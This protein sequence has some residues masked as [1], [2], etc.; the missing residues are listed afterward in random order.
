VGKGNEEQ[1][2][3]YITDVVIVGGGLAGLTAANSAL[4]N[5]VKVVILEKLGATGGNAK[6]SLGSFMVAEVDENRQFQVSDEYDTLN[7]ALGRWKQ[8]QDEYSYRKNAKYPDYDR[9]SYMFVQTMFTVDWLKK[10]GATFEPKTPISDRGMAMLQ[11]NV[12]SIQLTSGA[13]QLL[14]HLENL[15]TANEN[16]TLLLETPAYQLIMDGNKAVGVKAKTSKG[17]EVE[18]YAKSVILACGSYTQNKE[19]ME[20]YISDLGE[21]DVWAVPS[22][23]GDGINMALEEGAQLWGEDFIHPAPPNISNAFY[24]INP[25]RSNVPSFYNALLVDK[26]GTRIM[27]ENDTSYARQV[28]KMAEL[29]TGPYWAIHDDHWLTDA[30]RDMLNTGLTTTGVYKGDTL[31][32]IA[33]KGGINLTGLTASF[34]KYNTDAQNGV[35]TEFGKT[36]NAFKPYQDG[37]YYIVRMIPCAC[38]VLG[39]IVTNQEYQILNASNKPFDSLWAA[40]SVSNGQYYNQ[41]YFSGSSLTF[42]STSGR[43]VG[44]QAAENALK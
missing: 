29:K 7:A 28:L 42:A 34:N 1:D 38:D 13:A 24:A 22:D 27:K 21:V 19:M 33:E 3:Q 16:A 14:Q 8:Y 40:G 23:T 36:G 15:I 30:Q 11:V 43:L 17:G 5:G 35:D 4:Q 10:L 31:E 39:G 9:L 6:S 20:K 25:S 37:P 32:E 18:V 12:P 2:K 26:N 41:Y 44:K